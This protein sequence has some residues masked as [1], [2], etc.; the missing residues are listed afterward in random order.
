MDLQQFF[1]EGFGSH[2]VADALQE[3]GRGDDVFEADATKAALAGLLAE[4]D[5]PLS[6]VLDRFYPLALSNACIHFG[7]PAGTKTECVA[8]LTAFASQPAASS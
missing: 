6:E 2:D 7:L 4:M 3:L 1:I 5:M 8:A